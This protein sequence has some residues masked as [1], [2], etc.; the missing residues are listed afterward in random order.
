M[1]K[2]FTDWCHHA[3]KDKGLF[4]GI[5]LRVLCQKMWERGEWPWPMHHFN[6][7]SRDFLFIPNL[8]LWSRVILLSFFGN[9]VVRVA[10]Y[11]NHQT[12]LHFTKATLTWEYEGSQTIIV[13]LCRVCIH[14]AALYGEYYGM[15]YLKPR[16]NNTMAQTHR[17]RTTCGA[18]S[19]RSL[20]CSCT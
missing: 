8:T 15:I 11:Q 19:L 4:C 20:V 10:T 5:P 17:T 18:S 3:E 7:S 2:V 14:Q 6:V 12:N 16:R 1:E 13:I 9:V